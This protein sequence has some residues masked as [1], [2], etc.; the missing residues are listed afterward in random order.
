MTLVY[1]VFAPNSL[2]QRINPMI[3]RRML[4]A[5]VITESGSGIKWVRIIPRPEI[6]LIDVW[7]GT[8]KKKTAMAVIASARVMTKIS[9]INPLLFIIQN[10]FPLQAADFPRVFPLCLPHGYNFRFKYILDGH[11][12][13][14]N[15][16]KCDYDKR[17]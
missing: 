12:M 8:R 3:S 9:L 10:P 16:V 17:I 15:V 7:L 6:L 1:T 2:P 13:Q 4:S 14:E 11:D 5:I